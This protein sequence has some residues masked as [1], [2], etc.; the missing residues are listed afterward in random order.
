[1]AGSFRFILLGGLK[2]A[3]ATAS[4]P[5]LTM[6]IISAATAARSIATS[7]ASTPATATTQRERSTTVNF[8]LLPERRPLLSSTAKDD[9]WGEFSSFTKIVLH[10]EQASPQGVAV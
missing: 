10:R 5:T 7:P 1:M 6:T 9:F 2:L 8:A 3:V 4:A